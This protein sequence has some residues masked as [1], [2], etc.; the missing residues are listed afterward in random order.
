MSSSFHR[1]MARHSRSPHSRQNLLGKFVRRDGCVI[2][3]RIIRADGRVV[4]LACKRRTTTTTVAAAAAAAAVDR[5]SHQ[6]TIHQLVHPRVEIGSA[7]K[8]GIIPWYPLYTRYDT[9]YAFGVYKRQHGLLLLCCD[10]TAVVAAARVFM[11]NP[12]RESLI[13]VMHAARGACDTYCLSADLSLCCCY[14]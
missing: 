6:H 10:G 7:F 1:H 3:M 4:L 14:C 12:F 8:H 11:T 5:R 9:W 2:T 13:G